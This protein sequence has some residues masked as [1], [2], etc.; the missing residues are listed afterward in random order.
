[1]CRRAAGGLEVELDPVRTG[2]ERLG[3]PS[4]SVGGH[5]AGCATVL[6]EIKNDAI[7]L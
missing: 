3:T 2:K 1:V 4:W 5:R 6:H 7:V